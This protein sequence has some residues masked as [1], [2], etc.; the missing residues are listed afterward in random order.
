MKYTS[1]SLV[2]V[3]RSAIPG[4]LP[5]LVSQHHYSGI[6][7]FLS[8][9]IFSQRFPSQHKWSV[10][11][12]FIGVTLAT[13]GEIDYNAVISSVFPSS[14]TLPLAGDL[15]HL[16]C[17]FSLCSEVCTDFSIHERHIP[18]SSRVSIS[19]VHLRSSP[20]ARLFLS[21]Q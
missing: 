13:S 10:V 3:M 20:D 11:I 8:R 21:Q 16:Y 12:I 2:Q 1:I 19:N 15:P 7:M 14:N 17:L 6:T 5:S 9:F 4:S 18:T